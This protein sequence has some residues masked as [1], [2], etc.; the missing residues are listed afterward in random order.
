MPCPLKDKKRF[1]A[2][3]IT[4]APK[5]KNS[6][7]TFT[8]LT[9]PSFLLISYDTLCMCSLT[10]VYINQYIYQT[11]AAYCVCRFEWTKD[12]RGV[13]MLCTKGPFSSFPNLLSPP[14]LSLYLHSSLFSLVSQPF[15]SPP[16]THRYKDQTVRSRRRHHFNCHHLPPFHVCGGPV[17]WPSPCSHHIHFPSLLF[18]MATVLFFN[19][20]VEGGVS[21]SRGGILFVS[22]ISKTGRG[23]CESCFS[24]FRPN[25]AHPKTS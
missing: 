6:K 11:A 13:S 25:K 2:I 21:T 22:F 1:E 19:M 14:R 15:A 20:W 24:S 10:A 5:I 9:C 17:E 16:I 7:S 12:T 8:T 23:K 4:T 18:S 3:F